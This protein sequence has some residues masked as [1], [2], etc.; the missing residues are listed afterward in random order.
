MGLSLPSGDHV[1]SVHAGLAKTYEATVAAID[2]VEL[3]R[4][5]AQRLR[6]R[7]DEHA[8]AWSTA[9]AHSHAAG[10][11][12]Q[13]HAGDRP[14]RW[15][16]RWRRRSDADPV[17]LRPADQPHGHAAVPAA[18]RGHRD[19]RGRHLRQDA[20][21]LD[22]HRPR[23]KRGD[24]SKVGVVYSTAPIWITSPCSSQFFPLNCMICAAWMG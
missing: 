17:V 9:R 4:H 24:L 7:D 19:A 3:R 16:G 6:R 5:D 21:V 13:R 8:A 11:L 23:R 20:H 15:P 14:G 2:H 22:E 10:D 1:R 12:R 18:D